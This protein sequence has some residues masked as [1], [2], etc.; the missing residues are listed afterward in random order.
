MGH[1]VIVAAA[2]EGFSGPPPKIFDGFPV[3]L[4]RGY[5]VLPGAGFAGMVSPGL[6]SWLGRNLRDMDIV[7]VHLARDLVTLPAAALALML[8]KPVIV[9]T[10][11]MVDPSTKS[12]ARPLDTLLTRPVL[13]KALA[14][15]HLTDREH[16]EL[17]EVAGVDL[18]LR[19]LP[20][21]VPIPSNQSTEHVDGIASRPEILFLG[22]LHR[23]KR[24]GYMVSAAE[25]LEGEWPNAHF[26]VVG[27]DEGEGAALQGAVRDKN[28]DHYVHWE[29][30]ASPSRVLA[31]M[32]RASIFALPS[33]DEPF[34]MAVLQAMS[35]GLPVVVT[36]TCGLAVLIRDHGAGIVCDHSSEG[37]AHAV[38]MLLRD[39]ELRIVM[40]QNARAM[41]QS[42]CNIEDVGHR[43]LALYLDSVAASRGDSRAGGGAALH[44]TR[45]LGMDRRAGERD[46]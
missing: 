17:Q 9:Q 32:S 34:P 46:A 7:H 8:R 3:H 25:T 31:R 39:P 38:E 4:N 11:G 2:A 30:P 26:T 36:E 18:R 43:L 45:A 33:I 6:L 29:G 22:R 40:G 1:E 44:R 19:P 12:M 10:H 35:L 16:G 5:R 15:L 28:L 24:P 21:G 14:V 20:N 37:F 13:R 41:V 42:C 27:P 23:R